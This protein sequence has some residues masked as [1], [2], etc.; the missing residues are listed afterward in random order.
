MTDSF[1]IGVLPC[2]MGVD[3]S[4]RSTGHTTSVRVLP[5]LMRDRATPGVQLCLGRRTRKFR[6][7]Q[8]PFNDLHGQVFPDVSACKAFTH[9]D[10]YVRTDDDRQ[11]RTDRQPM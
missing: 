2:L 3:D 1:I 7:A 11:R 5:V 8:P 10:T 6:L 9:R 4:L